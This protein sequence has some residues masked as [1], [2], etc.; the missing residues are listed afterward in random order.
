VSAPAVEVAP[1]RFNRWWYD[2]I[3]LAQPA[4]GATQ[5]YIVGGEAYLRVLTA[6]ASIT[7][8][9]NVASRLISLDFIN[10]RTITY[11]RNAAAVLVPA[12]T[13]SQAFE[14]S[15]QRATSEWNTST[16]VFLPVFDCWLPPGF[17][18][19]FAVDSIQSGDQLSGLRLFVMRY[20]TGIV[21]GPENAFAQLPGI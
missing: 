16:P 4:A 1:A 13:T 19:K 5:S 3:D 8:D 6:R 15:A 20:P 7:T 14:W 11:V 10:A 2:W 9:S 18:V 12:S 21:G 17:T